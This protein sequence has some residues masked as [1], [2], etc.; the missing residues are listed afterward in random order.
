MASNYLVRYGLM[1]HVGAFSAVEGP[2]QRGQCVI[3]DSP[4][5]TE[6]GEV[7]AAAPDSVAPRAASR[8]V[9]LAGFDDLDHARRL[10]ADRPRRLAACETIF[11]QGVW[12][13]TLLDVEPLLDEGRTVVYYL[14]PHHLEAAGLRQAIREQYDLDLVLEPVGRDEPEPE[15]EGSCGSSCGSGGCG[16]C[17]TDSDHGSGHGC[18]GCAVKSLMRN[19][20]SSAAR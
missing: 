16:S 9:R 6:L 17:G 15:A 8:V 18:D 13:L 3:I 1:R 2:L 10:E 14:G 20:S 4:R 7:L 11:G 5:G 12:P 19:P